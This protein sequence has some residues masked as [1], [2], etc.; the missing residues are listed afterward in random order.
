MVHLHHVSLV[1]SGRSSPKYPSKPWGKR[2]GFKCCPTEHTRRG[3]LLTLKQVNITHKILNG[4]Y[5]T[6]TKYLNKGQINISDKDY[7]TE[8]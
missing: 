8:I 4:E 1:V 3:Q 6:R 2:E 5:P 7:W